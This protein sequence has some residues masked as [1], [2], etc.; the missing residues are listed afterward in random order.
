MQ[1]LEL[2]TEQFIVQKIMYK[3]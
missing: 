1:V 3:E 2:F